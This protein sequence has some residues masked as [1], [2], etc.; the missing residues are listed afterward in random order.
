MNR[1]ERTLI[2]SIRLLA[3]DPDTQ[4][5]AY[6]R[7]GVDEIALVFDDWFTVVSG[8]SDT[9]LS[10]GGMEQ[11]RALDTALKRMSGSENAELWTPGALRCSPEWHRIR[12]L[13]RSALA[14]VGSE[15]RKPVVE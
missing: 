3:S 14:A 15:Y 9:T 1:F 12:T 11:V 10:A 6:P 4:L 2:E 5:A 13:A 7:C 8:R